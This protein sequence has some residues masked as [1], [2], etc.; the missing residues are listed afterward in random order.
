[1]RITV[2]TTPAWTG[3]VGQIGFTLYSGN[4]EYQARTTAGITEVPAGSGIYGIEIDDAVLASKWVVWDTDNSE[5]IYASESFP[6][7]LGDYIVTPG[8]TLARSIWNLAAKAHIIYPVSDIMLYREW[9]RDGYGLFVHEC[10]NIYSKVA[11]ITLANETQVYDLPADFRAMKPRGMRLLLSGVFSLEL[12]SVSEEEMFE[13]Y[14][15]QTGRR[16]SPRRYY[17]PDD[18]SIGFWPWL[19]T[20]SGQTITLAYDAEAP[21]TL[22][23]TDALP[24][25]PFLER[26]L[27]AYGIWQATLAQEPTDAVLA[28]RTMEERI[29]N[30]GLVR[31]QDAAL[32]RRGMTPLSRVPG[33]R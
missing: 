5:P 29:W 7:N 33:R 24:I 27:I 10:G 14:V 25:Q 12:E 31:K 4:D 1:M 23:M 13:S 9:I 15:A 17:F 6:A 22:K 3:L 16:G 18:R 19:T 21:D 8:A 28:R 32:R 2:D 30:E 20:V 26:A 11:V